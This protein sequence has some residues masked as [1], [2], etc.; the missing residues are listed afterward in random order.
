MRRCSLTD[1][2]ATSRRS[3]WSSPRRCTLL[4]LP[5]AATVRGTRRKSAAFGSVASTPPESARAAR[6][7]PPTWRRLRSDSR[8]RLG[9]PLVIRIVGQVYIEAMTGGERDRLSHP[10]S[11]RA[12]PLAVGLEAASLPAR[13]SGSFMAV[14]GS[15]RLS[16][17]SGSSGKHPRSA[18]SSR[19]STRALE[20][21]I[22]TEACPRLRA[23]RT[24]PRSALQRLSEHFT[25]RPQAPDVAVRALRLAGPHDRK[26]AVWQL[27]PAPA[28]AE[29]VFDEVRVAHVR[30]FRGVS[31]TFSH[32][33]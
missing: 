26:I 7:S 33:V 11:A 2:L 3:P 6:R 30:S 22:S 29:A 15:G 19:R 31:E 18:S 20:R 14:G 27:I 4:L 1:G 8:R 9:T 5:P 10:A 12:P 13:V 23:S 32:W 17:S 16:S 25:L 21:L 28:V 24:A